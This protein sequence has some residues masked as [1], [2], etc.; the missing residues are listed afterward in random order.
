MYPPYIHQVSKQM[1]FVV[2]KTPRWEAARCQHYCCVSSF[3][4]CLIVMPVSLICPCYWCSIMPA[5]LSRNFSEGIRSYIRLQEQC[6]FFS[7]YLILK[8][9]HDLQPP[10]SPLLALYLSSCSEEEACE[11]VRAVLGVV[12][13][14]C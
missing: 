2:S 4:R 8:P 6:M 9:N 12:A 11:S 10:R 14:L 5:K 7:W 1:C 3:F 13:W